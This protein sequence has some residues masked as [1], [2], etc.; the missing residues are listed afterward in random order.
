MKAIRYLGRIILACIMAML[1][2]VVF[3]PI[4]VIWTFLFFIRFEQGHQFFLNAINSAF[5]GA[6][7]AVQVIRDV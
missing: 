2:T 4:F 7:N 1:M 5:K 6:H 3:Y